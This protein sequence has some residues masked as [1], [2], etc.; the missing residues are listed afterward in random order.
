[1]FLHLAPTS[2]QVR[3]RT[4]RGRVTVGHGCEE[5]LCRR[6]LQIDLLVCCKID[7]Q[8]AHVVLR[9][10]FYYSSYAF[11]RIWRVSFRT[12]HLV[13]TYLIDSLSD[14]QSY[15]SFLRAPQLLHRYE[16]AGV[17]LPTS[18]AMGFPALRGRQR[19]PQSSP[20]ATSGWSKFLAHGW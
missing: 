9:T 7:L 16:A 13:H 14:R 2:L 12:L 18:A 20:A 5:L 19:R 3:F 10:L 11:G 8:I 4:R 1:M 15:V 6:M 17:S